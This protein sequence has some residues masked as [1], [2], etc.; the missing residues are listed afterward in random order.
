MTNIPSLKKLN[1]LPVGIDGYSE[2]GAAAKATLHSSGRAFLK[3]L[4]GD[5]GL[6]STQYDIR[7]N[8]GG[9]AVSGEV[10]LHADHLY[11]QLSESFVGSDKIT[12]MY[13]SCKDR[14][15]YAGGANNFSSVDKLTNGAYP[16]FVARCQTLMQE[17]NSTPKPAMAKP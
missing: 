15:D 6:K 16:G 1:A 17:V 11:V 14:K 10:T 3:H 8:K 13:R 2:T 12:V 4:A 5:L 9:V 7:S